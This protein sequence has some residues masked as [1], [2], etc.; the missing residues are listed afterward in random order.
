MKNKVRFGILGSG[1]MGQTHAGLII[2]ALGPPN[3]PE[4][5]RG[6]VLGS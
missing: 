6:L 1:Y 2:S 5:I 4:K 3:P